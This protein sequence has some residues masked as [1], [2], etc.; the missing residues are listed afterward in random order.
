MEGG[1]EGWRE[2]GRKGVREGGRDGEGWGGRGGRERGREG[3][4]EG[5]RGERRSDGGTAVRRERWSD[6]EISILGL[7]IF[8][9]F[10]KCFSN[11]PLQCRHRG[12]RLDNRWLRSVRMGNSNLDIRLSV[13]I[14]WSSGRSRNNNGFQ[15]LFN[16]TCI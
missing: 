3:G 8:S 16:I 13:A 1:R 7:S 10:A 4:R 9:W 2:G 14:E 12:E 15:A 6:G 5:G 11:S